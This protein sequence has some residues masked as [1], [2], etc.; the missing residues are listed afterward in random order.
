M[1][2]FI[3]LMTQDELLLY[4]RSAPY[5]NVAHYMQPCLWVEEMLLKMREEG[6]IDSD[7]ALEILFKKVTDY[8]SGLGTILCYDWIPLPLVY[9]QVSS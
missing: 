5:N 2:F 7:R 1:H 6:S 8:R 3:G 9:T 4:Y